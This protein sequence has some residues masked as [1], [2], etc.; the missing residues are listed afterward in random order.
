MLWITRLIKLLHRLKHRLRLISSSTKRLRST[1]ITS[2]I[3]KNKIMCLNQKE[4]PTLKVTLQ[5]LLKLQLILSS[6]K[7]TSVLKTPFK[8]KRIHLLH[9]IIHQVSCISI[10]VVKG[11]MPVNNPHQDVLDKGMFSTL[12]IGIHQL[13]LKTPKMSPNIF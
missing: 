2:S 1:Y 11:S 7:M 5:K 8:I 9:Q 6:L 3:R 13:I 10:R 4:I 12:Q